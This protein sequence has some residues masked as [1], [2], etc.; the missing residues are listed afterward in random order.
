M[1]KINVTAVSYL[2][3][4]PFLYGIEQSPV[5]TQI[6]LTKEIPSFVADSMISGIATIGLVPVA[7]VPEIS[8]AQIIS[9]YGI[10]SNGE[11]GSV[12]I[13]A[14]CP[15]E[16]V[17]TIYLDYQ[18]RTSV[19]LA[20]ILLRDFWKVNPV[21]KK[22]VPGYESGITGSTAG[23]I[24][25]DR[26]LQLKKKFRYCYDLGQAW[27]ELTGLPFVF[28]CWV[29]NRPLDE[30]FVITFKE[31][32]KKGIESVEIVARQN[33]SFYPDVDTLDYLNNK[34]QYH[35]TAEMRKGMETFLE[36]IRIAEK[37]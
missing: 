17:E 25:G 6:N 33:E 31:A 30:L 5:I 7:V 26:S 3:T 28:A 37:I 23:L 13:Y 9:D 21:L 34:I 2:N 8:G 27:K 24:I 35:L 32:L 10:C 16:E 4:K 15:I 20:K 11:V 36:E 22:T 18:S 12:C 1:G 14:Q 29:T 19:E